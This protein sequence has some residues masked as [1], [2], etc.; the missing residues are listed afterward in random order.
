M[1]QPTVVRTYKK[2]S[3][4]R[5]GQAA[6][7]V[8]LWPRFGVDLQDGG[9]DGVLDPAVLFGRR[10]PLVLE[11]GFGQGEATVAMAAADPDRDV[12]A[13]DVH[14]PGAGVLLQ[15]LEGAGLS[16]VRV[17]VGDA[18]P[19][20]RDR[21]PDGSLDELRVF[22][23]DP[24]PKARHHKRRLVTPA[25]VALAASRLRPGGRLHLA[26]DWADYADAMLRA[27]DGEPLLHNASGGFTPR[28]GWRPTT[29]F[30][31]QGLQ[32]GHVVRDVLA[33]RVTA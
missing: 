11:I 29:R 15:R 28:P 12:L 20:L 8:D 13:V 17:V 9:T 23:P 22:F 24:W 14:R 25:F 7:L 31:T 10:A 6:A 30:E 26:T 21:V 19:L 27:V 2:R 3:R 16:N 1:T 33:H 32:K 4:I 18:V 5:P